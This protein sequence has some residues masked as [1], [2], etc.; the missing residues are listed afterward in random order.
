MATPAG[1]LAVGFVGQV[2]FFA[3]FLV[4]WLASERESRSVMPTAFW[5]LSLLG[6]AF[7][8]SYA[9]WRRDPV[10]IAG[11]SVG[12]LVYWRN[13]WLLRAERSRNEGADRE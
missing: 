3:R 11:Q 5:Y 7:L 4:Q 8:M 1:W 6:A 13:L 10:F 2:A 9:V 12:F